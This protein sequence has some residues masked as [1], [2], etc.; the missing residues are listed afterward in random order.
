MSA[1]A[2]MLPLVRA[3]QLADSGFPSG[4]FAFSWGLESALADG[5]VDRHSLS[6]WVLAE[7]QGRWHGFD[8]LALAGGFRA[9]GAALGDW[10]ATIDRLMPVERLRGASVQAGEALFASARALR[11]GL[12]PAAIAAERAGLGHFAVVHGHFLAV[13]GL[14]L[15]AALAVSALAMARGCFSAAVRLGATGAIAMQR[16][17]AALTPAIAAL[18]ADLPVPGTLPAGFSPLSDIALMRP[19]DGRLF[20]N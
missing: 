12:D 5:R 16:E 10:F 18:A 20:I 19:R 13:S 15:A 1:E 11:I 3:M 9:T 2:G 6:G 8:R 7:L 14:D 4:V 17:L